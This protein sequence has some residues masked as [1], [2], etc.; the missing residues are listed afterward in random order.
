MNGNVSIFIIVMLAFV[1]MF[2]MLC[3]CHRCLSTGVR[4][5]LRAQLINTNILIT[6]AYLG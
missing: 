6:D 3:V 4:L 1:W 5:S 2:V